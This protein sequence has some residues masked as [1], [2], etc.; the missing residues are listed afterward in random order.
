MKWKNVKRELKNQKA[1]RRIKGLT[2]NRETKGWGKGLG[3]GA[4]TVAAGRLAVVQ[5]TGLDHLQRAVNLI[6]V[7]I[8]YC[9]SIHPV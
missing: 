1:R 9:L 4:V 5:Q 7:H 6:V 8:I 2:M 3:K